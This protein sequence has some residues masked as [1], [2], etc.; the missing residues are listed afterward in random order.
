MKLLITDLDNTLYDW[1]TFYSQSF[2]AMALALSKRINVPLD[3][4]LSEYKEVHQ[5]F[6]NTE[7]PFATLELPSVIKYFNC[8]DK[9]YLQKELTSV[10]GAFS[11]KRKE[12][13]K[14]YPN[15]R[16]TLEILKDN[17]VKIVGHTEAL[18]FNSLYRIDK[19][20]ILEFFDHLYTLED[21]NSIHPNPKKVMSIPVKDDFIVKLPLKDSK[22]N[23][24]LLKYIC[25][26]EGVRVEDAIYVGDSLTKDISMAKEVG[27]TAVWA[28]YGR[29]FSPD[30]WKILVQITH[31]TKKDVLREEELKKAF[32]NVKPDF[33][34]NDF[35]EILTL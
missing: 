8:A 26:K 13:L 28:N 21:N 4:I 16:K 6:G 19:L 29:N 3:I 2:E 1:V 7:K 35:S 23:P 14:L 22:P 30:C 15:V 27:M 12:T 9:E 11:A 24:E 10:F 20:N 32:G 5:R 33:I 18:E 25:L 31:W 17:G 34:I